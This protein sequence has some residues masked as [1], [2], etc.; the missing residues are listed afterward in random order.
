MIK[1][2]WYPGLVIRA[3][4]KKT[5]RI[6]TV[7]QAYKRTIAGRTS[8][9]YTLEEEGSAIVFDMPDYELELIKTDASTKA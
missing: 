5:G 7:R 6:F 3:R 4:S 2:A 1:M 9:W 8:T